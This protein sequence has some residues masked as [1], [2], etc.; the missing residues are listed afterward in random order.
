MIFIGWKCI[1]QHPHSTENESC[2]YYAYVPIS[3]PTPPFS[4]HQKFSRHLWYGSLRLISI[5]LILSSIH[6]CLR[7]Y[8]RLPKSTFEQKDPT[9][10]S[11]FPPQ[12]NSPHHLLKCSDTKHSTCVETVKENIRFRKRI[13]ITTFGYVTLSSYRSSNS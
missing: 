12:P 7:P 10:R 3:S 6:G 1:R 8:L 2:V 4:P 5:C 11:G 9:S 13:T